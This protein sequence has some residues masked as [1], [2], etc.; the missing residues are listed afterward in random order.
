MGLIVCPD[1][2][3]RNLVVLYILNKYFAFFK[4]LKAAFLFVGSLFAI[5]LKSKSNC[6]F[7]GVR[8]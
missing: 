8:V 7:G 3:A 4:L 1:Y 5:F 2:N 6:C